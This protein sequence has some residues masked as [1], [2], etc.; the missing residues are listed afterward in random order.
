MAPSAIQDM[1]TGMLGRTLVDKHEA[2]LGNIIGK[3]VETDV[4]KDN[5]LVVKAKIDDN[6]PVA[7]RLFQKVADG[8]KAAFSVGG[9]IIDSAPGINGAK[10]VITKVDCSEEVNGHV[11]LTN[12]PANPETYANAMF[13]SLD[14]C[15]IEDEAP[16]VEEAAKEDAPVVTEAVA[17][18][19]VTPSEVP[20]YSDSDKAQKEDSLFMSLD[21]LIAKAQSEIAEFQKEGREFSADNKAKLLEMHGNLSKMLGLDNDD[22]A[23]DENPDSPADAPSEAAKEVVAQAPATFSKEQL[24]QIGDI[25]GD[26]IA[27]AFTATRKSVV[28]N[29]PLNK[30][31][32]DEYKLAKTFNDIREIA[33]KNKR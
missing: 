2:A 22:A 16:V 14:A 21:E 24:E 3:I 17:K 11:C 12:R 18:A 6:D 4:T 29:E 9:S 1:A 33:L 30:S 13:K 27:K 28:E 23:N 20:A 15:P 5:K 26:K 32:S 7:V 25:L 19:T 10:R 31:A 8:Y